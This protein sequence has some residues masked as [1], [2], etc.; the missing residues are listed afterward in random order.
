MAHL[1]RAQMEGR[2]MRGA[3]WLWEGG[4]SQAEIARRLGVSRAAVHLW[5]RQLAVSG[6]GRLR[7]RR[8]NGR[9]SRLNGTQRSRLLRLLERGA[10]AAGFRTDR[11]TMARVHQVIRGR[12]GVV[13]HPKYIGRLMNRLGWRF[14]RTA[15]KA[16][17][18]GD[19]LEGAWVRL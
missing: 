18:G 7:R 11:W 19:G 3:R 6:L 14:E 10:R 17:E 13:Y 4:L 15:G 2:R 12:F 9:P 16:A 5:A 1:N 8:P